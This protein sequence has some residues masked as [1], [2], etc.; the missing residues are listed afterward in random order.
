MNIRTGILVSLL[1]LFATSA[2]A[3]SWVNGYT[4]SDGTYVQGHMRS[5]PNS[6]VRDNYSYSGNR[7][8][9]TGS[10][11]SNRYYDSPSSDYYGQQPQGSSSRWDR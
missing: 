5:S 2:F 10:T 1:G 6:T 3:D 9:Y 7:N 4:R 11:G 8:P